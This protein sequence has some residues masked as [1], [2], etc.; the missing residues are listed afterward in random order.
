M[1]N[2]LWRIEE[3]QFFILY[4]RSLDKHDTTPKYVIY[5]KFEH[6]VYRGDYRSLTVARKEFKKFSRREE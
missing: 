5:H 2:A 3:N 6:P 1:T 4:K